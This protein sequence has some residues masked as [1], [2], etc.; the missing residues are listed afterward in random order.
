MDFLQIW[1][2]DVKGAGWV[3][4]EF[5]CGKIRYVSDTLHRYIDI[6]KAEIFHA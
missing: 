1:H 6:R 5:N 2:F 4:L 3:V